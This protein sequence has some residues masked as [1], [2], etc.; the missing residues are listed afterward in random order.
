MNFTEQY[1]ADAQRLIMGVLET[2]RPELMAAHGNV[3]E[4][5]KADA[6]VVTALDKSLEVKLKDALRVFDPAVG[7]WGEEHGREGN[8]ESFW[9]I[10]PIDGTE[11]FIRGTTGCRNI[12]TF[13]DNKQS[14]FALVYRFPTS[15]LFTAQ[16]GKPTLK[17]GKPVRLSERP[18]SRAWLEFS[19][20]MRQPD[21][22]GIYQRLR[23]QVAGITVHRDFLEILE[24]SIE[25]IIVYK[26]GGSEWDYAPRALLIESA[27]GRVTNVGSDAYDYRDKS[28]IATHPAI[29]DKVKSLVEPG[30]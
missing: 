12:L 17:N 3:A 9:L 22:Y 4:E 14:L 18:L 21:G 27:G 10:D 16:K 8:E 6:S 11:S 23:P 7:F 28:L 5:L 2:S 26:S 19:V 20:N 15:D 29:F 13:V 24:A 25:G 1:F 30:L